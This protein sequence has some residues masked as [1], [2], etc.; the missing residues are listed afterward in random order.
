VPVLSRPALLLALGTCGLLWIVA[1]GNFLRGD[2]RFLAPSVAVGL[3]AVLLVN[4]WSLRVRIPGF[5]SCRRRV[6][7]LSWCW[8]LFVALLPF[9]PVPPA[10]LVASMFDSA[11]AADLD[12]SG[13]APPPLPPLPLPTQRP[14]PASTCNAVELAAIPLG[15]QRQGD[16]VTLAA[17]AECDG[18][19]AEYRWYIL[20]PTLDWTLV[21]DWGP[22]QFAW[23]TSAEEP[24]EYQIAVWARAVGSLSENYEAGL[25][26]H[27]DLVSACEVAGA[28]A[29]LNSP[30]PVGSKLELRAGTYGCR[31]AEYRWYVLPPMG[32]WTLVHDWG[33]GEF[34]WDTSAEEPGEYQIAVWA[35]TPPRLTD[36]YEAAYSFAYTLLRK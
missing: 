16:D 22:G 30:Q 3:A 23:D 25:G 26:V 20:P 15:S 14:V 33:A 24:G 2:L 7:A 11:T 9:V 27:Y 17:A 4:P 36:D 6:A 31:K 10:S 32:E 28:R 1:L 21:Q 34:T 29:L 5:N 13:A 19:P 8:L 35:R 12:G 18:L